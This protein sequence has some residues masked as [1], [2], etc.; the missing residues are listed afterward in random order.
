MDAYLEYMVELGLLLGGSRNST[1][2]QM[3]QILELETA[4]ANITVPQDQR[5]D[6][7]KLYHKITIAELQ[8][9]PKPYTQYPNPYT[10]TPLPSPRYLHLNTLTLMPSPLYPYPYTLTSKA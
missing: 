1:E 6:E 10:R 9:N 7:E 4:L 3:R 5:R 2:Q 8:V